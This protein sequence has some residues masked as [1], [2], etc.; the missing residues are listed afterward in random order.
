MRTA[1]G[2][3]CCCCNREFAETSHESAAAPLS[4]GEAV[5]VVVVAE[6]NL[7]AAAAKHAGRSWY[8]SAMNSEDIGA[9][10]TSALGPIDCNAKLAV[11]GDSRRK[12]FAASKTGHTCA[13]LAANFRQDSNL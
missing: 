10:Q 2:D 8:T 12:G 6:A 13:S 3:C 1:D 4:L 11:S 5:A 9:F 7:R